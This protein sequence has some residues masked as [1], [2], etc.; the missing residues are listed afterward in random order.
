V[1]EATGEWEEEK[2]R[3]K[4]ADCCYNFCVD[5]ALFRPC[6]CGLVLMKPLTSESCDGGREGKL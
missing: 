1:E 2:E 3:E 4:D 6:R 5:E